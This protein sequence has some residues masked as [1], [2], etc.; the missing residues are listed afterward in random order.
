[1]GN[2]VEGRSFLAVTGAAAGAAE[3]AGALLP[4]NEVFFHAPVLQDSYLEESRA[5]F[6]EGPLDVK[7]LLFHF[8]D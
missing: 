7:G 5:L 1:M 2:Q 8:F 3:G 4:V 6:Y